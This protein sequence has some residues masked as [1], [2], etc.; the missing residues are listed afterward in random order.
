LT[1]PGAADHLRMCAGAHQETSQFHITGRLAVGFCSTADDL[2][3]KPFD[4]R[5]PWAVLPLGTRDACLVG[6]GRGAHLALSRRQNADTIAVT[7]VQ[8]ATQPA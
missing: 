8:A 5:R 6:S 1:V 7:D 3:E 4:V 2:Q